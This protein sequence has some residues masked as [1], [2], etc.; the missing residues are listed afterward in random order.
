MGEHKEGREKENRGRGFKDNFE[1]KEDVENLKEIL[2]VV[3]EKV[4]QLLSQLADVLYGKERAAQY[5]KA[6]AT[7]YKELRDAGMSNE[8][9]Y[10]LT[11][12]YMSA[13]SLGKMM[14]EHGIPGMG[15]HA[16][17]NVNGEE[18]AKEINEKV[19]KKIELKIEQKLKD[20]EKTGEKK[21]D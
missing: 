19:K 21:E 15:G 18:L 8:Q 1:D 17:G 4:P 11:Q 2:T 12:E 14:G 7:F 6:V 20:K 10:A 9:A 5:G 13:M 3:S 16:H